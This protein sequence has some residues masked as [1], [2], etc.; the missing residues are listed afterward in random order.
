MTKKSTTKKRTTTKSAP[1]VRDGRGG[2]GRGQVKV[3][4]CITGERAVNSESPIFVLAL[5]G[6]WV[7]GNDATRAR[8]KR[9]IARGYGYA[10][11]IYGVER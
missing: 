5:D 3:V 9:M 10:T 4:I 7:P 2:D 8:G 6:A 11:W 1:S